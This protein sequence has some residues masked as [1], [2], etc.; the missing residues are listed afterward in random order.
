MSRPSITD[1]MSQTERINYNWYK[2]HNLSCKHWCR[3]T[4]NGTQ[5]ATTSLS[6]SKWA[7]CNITTAQWRPKQ[8]RTVVT[9]LHYKIV[10]RVK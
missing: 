10:A 9:V 8:N 2:T 1:S 6:L 7:S 5:F 4:T 3:N